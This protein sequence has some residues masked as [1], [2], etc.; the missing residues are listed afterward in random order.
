MTLVPRNTNVASSIVNT[1][2]QRGQP[3]YVYLSTDDVNTLN[4]YTLTLNIHTSIF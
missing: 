4:V 2:V 1:F 3:H